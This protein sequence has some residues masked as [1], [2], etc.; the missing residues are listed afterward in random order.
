MRQTVNG[1]EEIQSY[2]HFSGIYIDVLIGV[3]QPSDSGFVFDEPQQY[4][5][6]RIVDITEARQSMTNQLIREAHSDYSNLITATGGAITTNSLWTSIDA[7]R[8]RV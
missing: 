1:Y 8:A 6:I 4:Q 5:Y 2:T 3:G 7:I